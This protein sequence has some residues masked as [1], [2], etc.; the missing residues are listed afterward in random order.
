MRALARKLDKP[1]Q[2][3]GKV[4]QNERQLSVV[5]FIQYCR[6]LDVSPFDGLLV[7]DRRLRNKPQ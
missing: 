7:V 3:V 5:E 1:H 2:F 4:E 6:A